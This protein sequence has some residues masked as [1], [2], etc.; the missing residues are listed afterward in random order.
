LRKQ[1]T[2]VVKC[3]HKYNTATRTV[4]CTRT[5]SVWPTFDASLKR[6]REYQGTCSCNLF[7]LVL[8]IIL[9]T[10]THRHHTFSPKYGTRTSKYRYLPVLSTHSYTLLP[11]PGTSTYVVLVVPRATRSYIYCT[12]PF[13]VVSRGT[14]LVLVNFPL[15]TTSVPSVICASF[16][17]DLSSA[18]NVP[19]LVLLLKYQFYRSLHKKLQNLNT[20]NF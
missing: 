13:F 14:V 18:V 5:S 11:V 8:K 15:A 3:Y 2:S 9:R 7:L 4:Q 20:N 17:H 19:C 10:A 16:Y 6:E 12:K 1:S